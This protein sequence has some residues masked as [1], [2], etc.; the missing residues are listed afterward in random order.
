MRFAIITGSHRPQS[1]SSKVGH[2]IER[3]LKKTG[4]EIFFLDLG[5]NPLPFWD[6][7]MWNDSPHWQRDW[8]P[9]SAELRTCDA[10]IVISPEWSG[11]VPAALKNFFLLCS[12]QDIGHKPGLIVAVS[13]SRGGSY[14]VAELRM[15]SYKNTRLCYI[16]EHVIVRNVE[17]VLN[18]EL[19]ESD[20]DRFIRTKL[21]YALS[22]LDAYAK[23]L[24]TVRESNVIDHKT[25]ANGM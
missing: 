7:G 15:S 1:Q 10:L 22:L 4:H 13:S 20:D 5:I 16:P 8:K 21:E 23:A 24:R 19:P 14:P 9:I 17:T 12:H 3:L 25:H 11:M 2:Y 18:K 6:E